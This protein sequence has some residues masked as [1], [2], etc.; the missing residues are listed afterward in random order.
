MIT[1]VTNTAIPY[2]S[3][4]SIHITMMCDQLARICE[5]ELISSAKI[6]RPKTFS[7]DLRQ[8]GVQNSLIKHKKRLQLFP[9]DF[10]FF[11]KSKKWYNDRVFYCRQIE[12]ASYFLKKK[13][14]VLLEIHTLPSG[15][16]LEFIK[17]NLDNVQFIGLI[18][19]THSLKQDIENRLAIQ[20]SNKIHVL[21]DAADISKFKFYPKALS[22]P[23]KSGYIG[24]NF[25]GKGY[26]IIQK[27]IEQS[28]IHL[29]L[30]GFESSGN[31]RNDVVF[32]GKVPYSFVPKA[33]ESFEIGLLPNQLQVILPN[34]NDIGKYTSPMKMFEYM[35]SG[36]VIVASDIPVIR[37]VLIHNYNAYL[38]PH[39]NVEMW[40]SAI[41][42]LNGNLNLA[43]RLRKQAFSDV[44]Q[45]YSYEARAKSI[46]Q[47]IQNAIR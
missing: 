40:I 46:H 5:M 26:E 28:N 38:V 13:A 43:E 45:K 36:K 22:H 3:A 29:E 34:G 2:H 42:E 10:S 21:P 27:L 9:K 17:N 32:H 1:I 37:E 14:T 15:L 20:N 16:E 7:K 24:S 35:A 47:I 12:V 33:M 11:Y 23:L 4:E 18:V 31:N 44:R 6:W 19:I 41:S 25:P 30:F 39:D 8:Y